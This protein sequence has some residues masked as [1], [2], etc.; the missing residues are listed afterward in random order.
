MPIYHQHSITSLHSA[1]EW[2]L[3][4]H[5]HRIHQTSWSDFVVT[6]DDN[7]TVFTLSLRRREVKMIWTLYK[8]ELSAENNSAKWSKWR[9][10]LGSDPCPWPGM[11]PE[12]RL[13]RLRQREERRGG[14]FEWRQMWRQ[15]RL[16]SPWLTPHSGSWACSLSQFPSSSKWM[17][18]SECPAVIG[19]GLGGQENTKIDAQCH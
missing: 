7:W 9:Q 8:S 15:L 14:R 17:S 6:T 18:D 2:S 1:L 12:Q 3:S 10:W 19:F 4:R 13:R 5:W 16:F 11:D